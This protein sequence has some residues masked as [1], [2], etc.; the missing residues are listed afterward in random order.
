MAEH[1]PPNR[2]VKA[3]VWES[4]ESTTPPESGEEPS[5]AKTLERDAKAKYIERQEAL[6]DAP[7]LNGLLIEE[8]SKTHGGAEAPEK[9][10][11]ALDLIDGWRVQV[12]EAEALREAL[13]QT[14]GTGDTQG[15][16]APKER[17]KLLVLYNEK[18]KDVQ[19]VVERYGPSFE[20]AYR[21]Y[22]G[23]RLK[24]ID[25]SAKRRELV[26]LQNER[27][28]PEFSTLNSGQVSDR[29]RARIEDMAAN[30][31]LPEQEDTDELLESLMSIYGEASPE[32]QA[33]KEE[34]MTRARATGSEPASKLN[35]GEQIAKLDQEI[36]ELWQENPMVRYF[37]RMKQIEDM[38]TAIAR[39]DDVLE[40]QTVVRAI[41]SL[42]SWEHEHQRTTIG[43]ILVGP[44]GT[45]K[46]TLVHHYL[47]KRERE[48][49]YI[50]LSEDVTRYLLYGSKNIEFKTTA[51]YQQK[52]ISDLGALSDE[53]FAQFLAQ[54]EK[55]MGEAF[56]ID[57]DEAGITLLA[58]LQE[59]LD[60][61]ETTTAALDPE[62]MKKIQEIK[63]R[64]LGRTKQAYNKE[65]ATQ[66]HHI[67]KKNGWRD[68]VII[69]A[70]RRGDSILFDEFNKNKNWSLIYGLMTAK[71]GE[72]WYF[73]DNDEHIEIPEEWRM[74]FTANIG[75][76][77]GVFEVPEALASRA[78][79]K[80]LELDYPPTSEEIDVALLSISTPDG[81]FLRSKDD[82]A[83]MMVLINNIFPNVRKTL[84]NEK[85]FIPLSYRTIR[86]L[87]EKLVH[88][89]DPKTGALIYRPTNKSFDEAAFEVFIDTY[90]LYEG[91][92]A[93]GMIGGAEGT[94]ANKS[95]GIAAQIADFMASG[96]LLLSDE[97]KPR[98]IKLIGEKR[99]TE[100]RAKAEGHPK[101]FEEILDEIMGRFQKEAFSGQAALPT[102]VQ[103][104]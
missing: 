101:A 58:Q 100:L 43:G 86:D 26:K 57:Q 97:V 76:K 83:K 98:M 89:R 41:N 62:T 74:Y 96:S 70:L 84:A 81:Y 64:V 67:V 6:A 35:V 94:G 99:Y 28:K 80:V 5:G 29:T 61:A 71:P 31:R 18:R 78:G 69:S 53:D 77:H 34:I 104:V 102:Q 93:P 12:R 27:M 51:E 42:Y 11:L 65:L 20:K 8:Y 2:L 91:T 44:P 24:F 32:Y 1:A 90:A 75:R 7:D 82:I 33:A 85:Q 37:Y 46:S 60:K 21:A 63:E 30:T 22:M 73:A 16:A 92:R 79:G 47:E 10:N 50:D 17:A 88:V 48:M 52:L 49:V 13:K 15:T 45:G 95:A 40:T 14:V 103:A 4:P 68:G 38:G 9:R 36:Q 39:G 56:H 87:A 66:F 54:N 3:H 23:E 55:I 59:E 25:F 72:K 19:G